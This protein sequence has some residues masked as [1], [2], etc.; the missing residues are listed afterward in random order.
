M[1]ETNRQRQIQSETDRGRNKHT[2]I[3]TDR[4]TGKRANIQAEGQT[5]R[6]AYRHSDKQADRQTNKMIEGGKELEGAS[7]QTETRPPPSPVSKM[8]EGRWRRLESM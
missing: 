1:T 3:V 5:D 6:L 7:R 4:Q 8:M 2:E